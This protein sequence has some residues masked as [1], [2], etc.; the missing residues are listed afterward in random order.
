M[1]ALNQL[2]LPELFVSPE[3]AEKL[4]EDAV[5]L[6]QWEMSAGQL[7]DLELLMNGGFFPL[8][9]FMTQADCNRVR[10]D[11]CLSSGTS[12]PAPVTLAVDGTFGAV[13]QPGDDVALTDGQD[14]LAIMSITDHWQIDGAVHLG[15]KVK[16]LQLP[17]GAGD[18]PN[19]LRE[20]FRG[21][22]WDEVTAVFDIDALE[23]LRKSVLLILPLAGSIPTESTREQVCIARIN[24]FT[25][26][27]AV[28]MARLQE[29]V[30]KNYGATSVFPG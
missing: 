24:L 20:I 10:R 1:P 7:C 27:D 15:G 4:A 21:N 17:A 6:P 29:I 28:S 30:A 2:A 26:P 12:W 9:G 3:S 11:G 19:D 22:G 18:R 14:V 8:R 16:G 25:R 5:K 23:K 13:V